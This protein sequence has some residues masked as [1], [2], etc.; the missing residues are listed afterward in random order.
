[1]AC[2]DAGADSMP[3]NSRYI[4]DIRKCMVFQLRSKPLV[5]FILINKMPLFEMGTKERE[6][7]GEVRKTV[8]IIIP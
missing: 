5:Y 3:L 7:E 6:R 8:T 2:H 4:D 1:M